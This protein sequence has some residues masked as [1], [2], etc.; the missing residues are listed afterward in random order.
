MSDCPADLENG[1]SK[2]L[3]HHTV[4]NNDEFTFTE[5]L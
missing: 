1:G 3:P 5:L 2:M 4:R